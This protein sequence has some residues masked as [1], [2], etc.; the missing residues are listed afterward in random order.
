MDLNLYV[1][2][3]TETFY[4]KNR[5]FTGQLDSK[6]TPLG[7]RQ[8]QRQGQKLRNK[9]IV[10]AFI[11]P[12]KRTHETLK[13]IRKYYPKFKV[14]VDD[15]LIERDYG[16]MAGKSKVK[17][18]ENHPG[19]YNV[20]HRSY[21]TPPPHGE[22]MVQVEKRVLRALAD[23]IALMKK[24]RANAVIVAHNNSVRPIRRYFEKMTPRE[25]MDQDNYHKIFKYKI[26]V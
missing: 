14:I 25:M 23:I 16:D 22:S 15:R 17:F 8:A 2:T 1:L 6:L 21:E 26:K 7:H 5:I 3:H 13:Y 18:R 4:N 12:L 24:E 10:W 9:N 11:S 20:Y 19:F